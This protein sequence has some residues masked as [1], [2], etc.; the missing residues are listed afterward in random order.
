MLPHQRTIAVV[1]GGVIAFA[2]GGSSTFA[3]EGRVTMVD[4]EGR[5][6]TIDS[7]GEKITSKISE[8]RTNVMING[9]DA[10]PEDV[11]VGMNCVTDVANS[12]DEATTFDCLTEN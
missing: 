10:K 7:G 4:D 2:V 1:L 5:A 12:G 9:A 11:R 8:L 3:G 6:I